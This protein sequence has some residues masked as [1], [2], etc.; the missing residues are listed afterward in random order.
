RS[1]YDFEDMEITTTSLSI[2]RDLHCWEMSLNWVPFG[3]YK[4]FGFSIYVKSGHLRDL[5]RLDVPKQD[6]RG[7]F[8]LA[9]GL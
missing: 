6:V 1:G 5:L 7:R 4:S 2:L 8:D 9:G 3:D